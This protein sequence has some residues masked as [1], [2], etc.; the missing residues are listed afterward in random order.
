MLSFARPG[1]RQVANRR[2]EAGGTMLKS[3]W[4]WPLILLT[5]GATYGLLE[6][7][8]DDWNRDFTATSAATEYG[9]IDPELQPVMMAHTVEEA[10]RAVLN[11]T[12]SLKGWEYGE[13]AELQGVRTLYFTR[14][15]PY[16]QIVDDVTVTIANVEDSVMISAASV[17]RSPWGDLGRNPRNLK[18]LLRK[19]REILWAE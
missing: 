19:V 6:W 10:E 12:L 14:T 5:A 9:A 3:R 17:S 2:A 4:T 11:A 18:A 7:Q 1:G 13:V 8:V 15:S 16:L